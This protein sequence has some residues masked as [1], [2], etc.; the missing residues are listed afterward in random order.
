MM[1]LPSMIPGAI[2]L[3]SRLC[4]VA[5]ASHGTNAT[6]SSILSTNTGVVIDKN[7]TTEGNDHGVLGGD[8]GTTGSSR[9][10]GAFEIVYEIPDSGGL[11][12]D[13]GG[14]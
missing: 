7:I 13:S 9:G 1:N 3:S 8:R 6:S 4:P 5:A 10:E 14:R 2:I 11:A 12:S